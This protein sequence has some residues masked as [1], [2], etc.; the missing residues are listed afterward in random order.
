MNI[1]YIGHSTVLIE[2][3]DFNILTDPFFSS[4]MSGLKRKIQPSISV[5][6]LPRIDLILVSHT[7]PDHC[8]YD[9]L[10]MLD[11]SSTVIMPENTSK[12]IRRMGF[13]VIELDCW[14][15]KNFRQ[16]RITAVP[17]KHQGKCTG[18]VVEGKRSLYFAGDTMFTSS[19]TEIGNR[20][21]PD[22]A[23]LPIGGN[24][25][26]GL[27]MIMDPEDAALAAEELKSKIVIPIHSGTF[28]NIPMMFYMNGTPSDF[29]KYVKANDT[30]T[31]IEVLKTGESFNLD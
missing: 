14:E 21:K 23:L 3:N 19:M 13:N 12:K 24:R 2:D 25:F 20:Y 10:G 29:M 18:F 7:H 31:S 30:E 22:V 4:N 26:F 15:S 8:D 17:A 1:T 9:A 11:K 27:K 16:Y 28:G 6:E 5:E